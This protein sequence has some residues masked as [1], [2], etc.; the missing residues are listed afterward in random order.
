MLAGKVLSCSI[1]KSVI[2]VKKQVLSDF[3]WEMK[4]SGN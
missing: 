1:D 3:L 2:R 4:S